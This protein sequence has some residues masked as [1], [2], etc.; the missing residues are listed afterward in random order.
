MAEIIKAYRQELPALRFIGKKYGDSDRIDGMFSA[1]WGEFFQKGW[2][3]ELEKRSGVPLGEVY[4][5]GD[6]YLGMMRWKEGEPFEY[7]IGMFLPRGTE[8]PEGFACVDFPESA[9]GVCWVYGTEPEVYMQEEK[10]A[11][12][13]KEEGLDLPR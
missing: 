10:S 5:D 4:E 3:Q 12:R 6:A 8:V 7:W 11:N 9:L 1:K 13:L 2:F